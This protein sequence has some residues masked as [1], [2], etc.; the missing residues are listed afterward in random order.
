MS[1]LEKYRSRVEKVVRRFYH[2][3]GI[4]IGFFTQDEWVY[5]KQEYHHL[6]HYHKKNIQALLPSGLKPD[7]EETVVKDQEAC[8]LFTSAEDVIEEGCFVAGPFFYEKTHEIQA[9]AKL[10]DLFSREPF[11]CL[12]SLHEIKI[13]LQQLKQEHFHLSEKERME[14]LQI[15]YQKEGMAHH[16]YEQEKAFLEAMKEGNPAAFEWLETIEQNSNITLGSSHPLRHLKNKLIM[17]CAILCRAA[18]EN[19]TDPNE[20]MTMSDYFLREI[21]RKQSV[22]ALAGMEK[23]IYTTFFNMMQQKEASH[24]SVFVWKIRELVKSNVTEGINLEFISEYVNRTPGYISTVF[25]K[26]CGITLKQFIVQ[27]KIKEAKKYLLHTDDNIL[28]IAVQFHFKDQTY[29]TKVFKKYTGQT[30]HHFRQ[31]GPVS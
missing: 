3:T 7:A 6:F 21:E 27:E 14:A 24:Y 26:E 22:E 18:M 10:A 17:A 23:Q 12:R 5:P 31:Y 25:K 30:P 8:Y 15:E 9:P 29:F 19:G 28:D 4:P 11:R 13:L 2:T 16:P 20:A 1:G